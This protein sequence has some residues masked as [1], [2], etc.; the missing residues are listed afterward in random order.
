MGVPFWDYGGERTEVERVGQERRRDRSG[1][2][3]TR[4]L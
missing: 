3:S 2:N 4:K 1:R